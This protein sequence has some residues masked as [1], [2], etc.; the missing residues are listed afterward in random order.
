MFLICCYIYP[1]T[2]R[3]SHLFLDI[4]NQFHKKEKLKIMGQRRLTGPQAD[5]LNKRPHEQK[6]ASNIAALNATNTRR[7]EV[8]RA[9]RRTS[10]NVSLQAS[11]H[12]IDV[13][14]NK[15]VYNGYAGNQFSL[16]PTATQ[17]SPRKT[18]DSPSLKT[19]SQK[20][21]NVKQQRS[22]LPKQRRLLA[23]AMNSPSSLN[24]KS[25]TTKRGFCKLKKSSL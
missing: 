3:I 21:L 11:Q 10:E 2:P 20:Q 13:P 18:N 24:L 9:Q 6:K 5:D 15:S 4:T 1:R 7:G 17:S 23:V 8:F 12:L 22:S 19:L 25:P 16:M 14:V